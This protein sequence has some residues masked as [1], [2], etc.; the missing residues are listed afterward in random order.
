M[1][2]ALR[3]RCLGA[4]LVTLAGPAVALAGTDERDT[5][6]TTQAVAQKALLDELKGQGRMLFNMYNYGRRWDISVV[7][8]DGAN[9]RNVFKAKEARRAHFERAI[10]Q[11]MSLK[12][13][14]FG[15]YSVGPSEDVNENLPRV[16][17]G[18]TRLYYVQIAAIDPNV[19]L[20]P[21]KDYSH[22]PWEWEGH[23]L[24]TDLAGARP[25]PV[26]F[27]SGGVRSPVTEASGLAV[28]DE[29]TVVY[30]DSWSQRIV[31]L[32][33]K[34]G[35]KQSYPVKGPPR[36]IAASPDGQE[37]WYAAPQ[38]G[39]RLY[40]L[41]RRTEE[42]QEMGGRDFCW[43][44]VSHDGK[45][46]VHT[47]QNRPDLTGG[48]AD[49]CIMIRDETE[50][51]RPRLLIGEK[52]SEFSCPAWGPDDKYLVYAVRKSGP[53]TLRVTRLSDM[54]TVPINT[55]GNWI[56]PCWIVP[57]KPTSRPAAP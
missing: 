16:A 40:R 1:T 7:N 49:R 46:V 31:V 43:P 29:N 42:V 33:V 34:T 41:D 17:P 23:L 22:I 48:I 55:G 27:L 28:V 32:N 56:D 50:G 21:F 4:F 3:L 24:V 53:V 26:T 15:F 35:E 25:E 14:M 18:G 2:T 10:A 36:H 6:P 37:I 54:V 8:A 52:G 38:D 13:A 47:A 12:N 45:R 5:R 11:G 44:A 30:G 39:W 57:A 20:L 9:V 51:G 19:K